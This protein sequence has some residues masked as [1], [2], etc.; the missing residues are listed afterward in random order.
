MSQVDG[1]ADGIPLNGMLLLIL[2]CGLWGGNLV[3]IKISNHGIPPLMAATFRSL[4]A[5]LLLWLYAKSK[6]AVVL[7]RG[8]DFKHA[9]AL[10]TLF[11]LDF[12]FLYLGAAYTDASRAII[13]LYTHPLWVAIGAHFILAD[14]RLTPTK[15]LGMVLAFLGLLSVFGSHTTS[16][17]PDHWI[18]DLLEVAAAASWASCTI[19]IKRFIRKRPISHYQTL[20]SQLFFS[21]PT[22]AICWFVLESGKV[23]RIDS[24]VVSA[25]A[26]QTVVVAFFSYILW[27]WM[28][29]NYTV[30][31]LATFTFLAPLFGVL[32]SGIILH[33]PLPLL[34]WVGL[35]LV[36]AGIYFVNKPQEAGRERLSTGP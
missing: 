9:V 17:R 36:A 20:F 34:L 12:I 13:F 33:E 5:S 8:E 32:L 21:V 25:L 3:S 28:I 19:Y 2:V 16:L 30:T 22:M 10:G 14:D 7:L 35:T 27:F 26:Y 24:V 31:R 29:H 18:G 4:V 23:V 6:G 11:A 1:R 15:G